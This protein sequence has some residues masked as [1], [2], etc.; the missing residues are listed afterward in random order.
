MWLVILI[1]KKR[2]IFRIPIFLYFSPYSNNNLT[3][4]IIFA[5]TFN[6]EL[7]NNLQYLQEQRQKAEQ[8]NGKDKIKICII[9]D[10]ISVH[11]FI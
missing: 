8:T 10:M 11:D 3:K 1:Q 7:K 6:S 2:R 4:K 5:K 9:T